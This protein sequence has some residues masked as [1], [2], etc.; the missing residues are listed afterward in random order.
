MSSEKKLRK[1]L[2]DRFDNE[3]FLLTEPAWRQTRGYVDAR[4]RRERRRAAAAIITV[5]GLAALSFLLVSNGPVKGGPVLAV[6]PL[7]AIENAMPSVSG[8]ISSEESHVALTGTGAA[9]THSAGNIGLERRRASRQRIGKAEL[10][11]EASTPADIVMKTSNSGDAN[12][13]PTEAGPMRPPGLKAMILQSPIVTVPEVNTSGSGFLTKSAA[14][15][16]EKDPANG[17]EI[18]AT[19]MQ[20]TDQSH[21]EPK[22]AISPDTGATAAGSAGPTGNDSIL[23]FRSRDVLYYEIGAGWLGGWKYGSLHDGRGLT[24]IGGIGFIDRI[25]NQRSVSFGV[26][27]MMI[28]NL[29]AASRTSRVTSFRFGEESS[30]TVIKPTTLHYLVI[31]LR[32]MHYVSRSD[33]FGGGINLGYLLNVDATISRYQERPGYRSDPE[34]SRLSGYTEGFSWY[35]TQL[36]GFYRRDFGRFFGFQTELFFGLVDIK[37]N[38]FF[39]QENNERN[40]GIKLTL[41]YYARK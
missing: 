16:T 20:L 31:P 21:P 28:S 35:D 33:V 5:F 7:V 22:V 32:Y 24:P 30:V 23:S 40:S 18:N 8:G 12:V 3:E 9:K 37:N 13:D 36:S 14:G 29:D 6:A 10:R 25:D 38:S 15:R 39:R 26:Q 1:F 2:Q 41:I 11:M 4:R 17:E 27:Y 19:D 34:Q